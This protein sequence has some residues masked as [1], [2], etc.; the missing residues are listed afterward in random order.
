MTLQFGI[1]AKVMKK[2]IIYEKNIPPEPLNC[3][4]VFSC[5]L[6]S[7][8]AVSDIYTGTRV[9]AKPIPNPSISLPSNRTYTL[10]DHSISK[11]LKKYRIDEAINIYRLPTQSDTGP[12]NVVMI[13]API[14]DIATIN[15]SMVGALSNLNSFLM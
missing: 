6:I 9:T 11:P 5:P 4:K 8:G 15:P 7:G 3:G 1:G 10:G 12:E 14:S 13:V 2:T